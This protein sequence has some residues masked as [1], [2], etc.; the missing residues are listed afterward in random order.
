MAK[1]YKPLVV[2]T[3]PTPGSGVEKLQKKYRVKVSPWINPIKRNHLLNYVK[4]ADAILSHLTEKIDKELFDAAGPQLKI[5]ANYAVGF[6]NIDIA[7][8]NRR[9]IWVTNTPGGFSVSVAEHTFTLMLAIS[10]KVVES[11]KF[12]RKGH[13]VGWRPNLFLGYELEGKTLG[14]I[15]IGR[16]G[17]KVA[18]IAKGFGM[19]ILYHDM[20]R[21][22]Q[23]ERLYRAKYVSQNDLLERSDFVSLNVPLLPSTKHLIGKEAFKKM[24]KTAYLINTSRGPVIDE[25]ALVEALRKNEIGGA[26]LDVFEFEPDLSAGLKRLKNVVLTPH[27]ASGT[28]ESRD[29]MSKIATENIIAGLKGETP[30]NYI[31]IEK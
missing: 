19:K 22:P 17:S 6:D 11:D 27:T 16:I 18:A 25:L 13:Y 24:K 20:N 12:V 7:E 3:H 29:A 2:V 8:A 9:N 10:R 28:Y 4:G 21:I 23:I 14:I 31:K 5:V 26:G 1:K 30:P 15:G